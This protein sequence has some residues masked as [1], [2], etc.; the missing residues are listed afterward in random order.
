MFCGAASTYE[1]TQDQMSVTMDKES[2]L[3]C[4]HDFAIVRQRKLVSSLTESAFR[5]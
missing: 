3:A 4:F 2:I 5:V 1:E